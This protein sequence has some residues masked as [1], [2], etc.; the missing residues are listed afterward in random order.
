MSQLDKDTFTLIS[1][2]YNICSLAKDQVMATCVD[3]V[4][5]FRLETLSG[6]YQ[7]TEKVFHVDITV[8]VHSRRLY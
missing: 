2:Y 6:S 5:V 8:D 3:G 7:N 4:D 1:F